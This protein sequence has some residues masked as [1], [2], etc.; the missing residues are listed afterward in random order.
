MFVHLNI[1]KYIINIFMYLYLY[2]HKYT[3]IYKNEKEERFSNYFIYY[4]YI[5]KLATQCATSKDEI[6][7]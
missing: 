6:M 2:T 4:L 7:H 5:R 1:Y 3:S